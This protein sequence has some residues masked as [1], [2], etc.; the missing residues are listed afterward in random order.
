MLGSLHDAGVLL[1][2]GT[3]SGTGG[4]GIVPGYSIHDELRILVENGFSPYEAI[5]AGTVNAAIVVERMGGDG[6]FGAIQVGKRA[7]LILVRDNPLEDVSTI[8]E[9]LGVMAA[10]KWY[11]QETLAELIEPANLPASEKE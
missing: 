11:S 5:A 8:K 9:P 4:M 7:D 10:G 2:L 1:L 6:D 3:D